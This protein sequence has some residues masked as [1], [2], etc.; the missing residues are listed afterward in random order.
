[1]ARESP[2][3][4]GLGCT[5]CG[6]RI[7]LGP[8]FEGCR[9]CAARG[10]AGALE[11]IYADGAFDSRLL[12]LW[13]SRSGG[14]WRFRELLPLPSSAE[15]ITLEE[16]G[17]P[18]VRLEADGPA[19]IWLKDETR[20]P[21]GA[22]KDRFHTVSLSMARALGYRKV[23]ASTTGNHGTSMAAYAAKGRL[24]C[25]AFCD[26]RAPRLQ[27]DLMQALGARVAVLPAR[28]DHLAWLV[29]ERGWYP[30]TYMTPMPV[31]TPFGVEG[32][33]TIGH[34]VYFQLGR[35]FPSRL[36][37][38]TAIGDVLYGPWKGFRELAR[39]GA[40]GRL[41]RMVAV[42]AAG[43]DPIVRG[44]QAGASVVP[45][46]PSPDTIALSIGDETAG[47]ITLQT[48]RESDGEAV[49]VTDD[50]IVS[51][52]RA[53][54]RQAIVV[55]PSS[56]ATVAAA[57]AMA[58]DGRLGSGEDVVCILTGAG[59]KWPD[60]VARIAS[61]AELREHDPAAFRGWIAGF[62]QDVP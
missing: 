45:V 13:A 31:S 3:V 32:Y 23:T 59:A 4:A 56:A 12:D 21:T 29:R 62:D 27:R 52:M 30:S 61:P 47:P 33:K 20:N 53:L 55:E 40:A 44:F 25:L 19:R 34:E 14:V 28:R 39:L 50:A 17:T 9:A 51:A 24:A 16:G 18:L 22:F 15:P 54:A 7:P 36:L 57:L 5:A 48:L 35:R 2:H 58:A 41:P 8:A 49:A 42:Q 11:V 10:A 38:P 60:E 43:C 37:A 46:H 6:A 26:P 1:M